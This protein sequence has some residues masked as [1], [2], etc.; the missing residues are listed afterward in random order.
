MVM[1]MSL[2]RMALANYRC[3]RDRQELELRPLTIVL[4]KNNSGKSALVRAPLVFEAGVRSGSPAPLDLDGL[5]ENTLD[6]FTDLV[7]G[8]RPHG[9]ID[10][11]LHVETDRHLLGLRASVQNIAEYR[12]QVVEALEMWSWAHGGRQHRRAR[13][14]WEVAEPPTD[15]NNYTIAYN[16]HTDTGV[17]V[18][19]HGLLPANR[20]HPRDAQEVLEDARAIRRGYPMIRYFGPFRNRPQRRYRLPA[21]MPAD[22]GIAGE[23]TA[24]ALAS[25]Y[26]RGQGRLARDINE[27]LAHDLPG[28]GIEVEERGGMYSINLVSRDDDSLRVNLADTGAGVSQVL[29]I[30]AQR[31]MDR[32]DPPPVSTLEIVE[33]P[34]LHLHPAAH[35]AVADLYAQAVTHTGVRFLIETH[36]ETLLL[37]IRRRIAEGKLDPESVAVYFVEHNKGAATLRGIGIDG[38]GNLDYWPTGVFSEDYEETRALATAQMMKRNDADAR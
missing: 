5:D 13:F 22:I 9:S 7:Y 35:R 6:S 15:P 18:E 30:L 32:L 24:G 2:V 1:A 3:F 28:W 36:S 14:S 27:S 26:V 20:Y 34:E 19:F 38:D 11:E 8:H 33:Q 37:R 4:G 29:P 12:T 16:A 17:P 31:A 25:D 10:I 21:R 23:Q